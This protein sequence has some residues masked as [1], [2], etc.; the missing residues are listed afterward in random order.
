MIENSKLRD[1]ERL[2]G[3]YDVFMFKRLKLYARASETTCYG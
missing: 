2:S 1:V 3:L